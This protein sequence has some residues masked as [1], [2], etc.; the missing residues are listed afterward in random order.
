MHERERE[1]KREK[2]KQIINCD[3]A[4]IAGKTLLIITGFSLLVHDLSL[5][6]PLSLWS[7]TILLLRVYTPLAKFDICMQL[8]FD[9]SS[10][11][12]PSGE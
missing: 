10:C 6:L 1:R 11:G 4:L 5:A 3:A 9:D 7:L 12:N 8:K 2:G